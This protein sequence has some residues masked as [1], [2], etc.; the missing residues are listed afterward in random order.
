[1][2]RH[3]NVKLDYV[4]NE[5][6]FWSEVKIIFPKQTSKNVADTT[7]NNFVLMS[8]SKNHRGLELNFIC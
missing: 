7:L 3:E 5:K 4:K 6:S 1:M 8:S 2:L